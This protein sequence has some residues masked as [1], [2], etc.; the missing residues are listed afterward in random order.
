MELLS[1]Y[2][3]LVAFGLLRATSVGYIFFWLLLPVGFAGAA[4]TVT[5]GSSPWPETITRAGLLATGAVVSLG[6]ASLISS[7]RSSFLT[8][9]LLLGL[10]YWRGIVVTVDQPS[11][12]EVR[13]RFGYGFGLLFLG[14]IW[15]IVWGSTMHPSGWQALALAG[16]AYTIV[17]M[18]ALAASRFDP[19]G[20]VQAALSVATWTGAQLLILL[21]LALT[22][23][24]VFSLD[25]V[26][27]VARALQP[28]ASLFGRVMGPV[29]KVLLAPLFSLLD[30]IRRHNEGRPP[31]SRSRRPSPQPH[32]HQ[33]HHA[34][35]HAAVSP[36][37]LLVQITLVSLLLAGLIYILWRFMP[38][39]SR[40][41]RTHATAQKRRRLTTPSGWWRLVLLWLR[42]AMS[43]GAQTARANAAR[44]RE[45]VLGPAYPDDPVR[46]AYAKV[47]RRAG[48]QGLQ[49]SGSATPFEFQR[50]LEEY[51]PSGADDFA[52]LTQ[53]YMSRRYGEVLGAGED[54][55]NAEA[56]AKRL[57][58]VMHRH[59]Q[60]TIERMA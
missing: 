54:D 5:L 53:A 43:Q 19:E 12:D 21:V 37:L 24:Q 9:T 52:T 33:V 60:D 42:G 27:S 41:S 8:A 40:R 48:A 15:V 51:W 39:A 3:L 45:S 47:L 22:S 55:R 4:V 20:G 18:I 23:L 17:G 46:R 14:I 11:Y 44:L 30:W 10:A 58:A 59:R 56:C 26:G 2:G 1:G 32:S 50:Q 34:L 7:G 57:R 29:A 25:I 16:I 49:R 36:L 38:R 13:R 6:T 35:T 28:L 31:G